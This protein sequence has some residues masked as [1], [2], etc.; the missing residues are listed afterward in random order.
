MPKVDRT[1]LMWSF[2]H[3]ALEL[4]EKETERTNGGTGQ[5]PSIEGTH[6]RC[7]DLFDAGSVRRCPKEDLCMQSAA[8]HF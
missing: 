1:I 2:V 7:S 8:E 5:P 6:V 4:F 3:A